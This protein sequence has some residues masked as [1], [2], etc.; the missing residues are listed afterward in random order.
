MK[1]QNRGCLHIVAY[2]VVL[3]L[4]LTIIGCVQPVG[5]LPGPVN[6][7][8]PVEPVNP[9]P[10]TI[11]AAAEFGIKTYATSSAY[12]FETLAADVEAGKFASQTEFADAMDSRTKA[13]RQAAF[14]EMRAAWAAAGNAADTWDRVADAE[15]CRQ[16]AAGFRRAVAK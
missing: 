16:T 15:K 4:G 13:A 5:P 2:P 1:P 12:V 9:A 8:D 10:V 14:E 11:E 6:P 7:V 3:W